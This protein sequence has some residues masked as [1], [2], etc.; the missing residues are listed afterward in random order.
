MISTLA[1]DA[2]T[3]VRN[4]RMGKGWKLPRTYMVGEKGEKNG[5][6]YTVKRFQLT[7]SSK[8]VFMQVRFKGERS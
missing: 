5:Q 3:R 4:P 8:A 2:L 1:N 6:Q 7:R